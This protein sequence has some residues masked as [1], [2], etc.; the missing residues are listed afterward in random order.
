MARIT[1]RLTETVRPTP[2]RTGHLSAPKEVGR[3]VSVS[4]S[5]QKIRQFF[6]VTGKPAARGPGNK[7]TGI[8]V[9]EDLEGTVIP[10]PQSV[11]R[12]PDHA[13]LTHE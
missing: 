8:L 1:L 11:R 12:L 7:P 5:V 13:R 4:R 3:T 10:V 6:E 9:N 2:L